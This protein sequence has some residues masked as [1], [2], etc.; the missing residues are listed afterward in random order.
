MNQVEQHHVLRVSAIGCVVC[1]RVFDVFTPAQIH[2]V[3]EGSGLRSWFAVAPLCYE[4]H[5]G[6]TGL[7]GLSVP[8]FCARYRLPNEN[9]YGLLTWVNE[10]LAL[11]DLHRLPM[12]VA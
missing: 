2:H 7:H 12:A 8:I 9:E 6:S 11:A 1:R 5:E 3:A 4:H 10:D